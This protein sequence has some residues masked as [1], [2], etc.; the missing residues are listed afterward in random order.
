MP[1]PEEAD[2]RTTANNLI[3]T[4]HEMG[5]EAQLSPLTCVVMSCGQ[6]VVHAL[7]MQS[8]G[9]DEVKIVSFCTNDNELIEAFK[10]IVTLKRTL[11]TPFT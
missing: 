4:V 10:S 8:R 2:S 11:Q 6:V 7:E 5:A 1:L 9:A 3:E